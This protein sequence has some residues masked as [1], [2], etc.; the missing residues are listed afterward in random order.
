MKQNILIVDDELAI[1][2]S[3]RGLLEDE[4][5]TVD[6]AD[7]GEKA[8]ACIQAD[9]GKRVDAVLLDIWLPKMD[10]MEVLKTIKET[11]PGIPVIMLSGHA[12]IET[13]VN[14]TKFGAYHFI[15]KPFSAENL[16]LTLSHALRESRLEQE[17]VQ[18][19]QDVSRNQ[20]DIVGESP[21]FTSMIE[22]IGLAAS[23]DAWVLIH[24][25]NGTGKESVAHMVHENSPR[26]G[27]PF[28]E[29]NCAAI[30]EE[31]IESELFGHEK[32]SFTGATAKK[33]GKFD[34]ANQGTLF[35]DEIGDMSLK[36]Q[37]KILRVLQ[38]QRFERVGG[39]KT[40]AVNVRVIAAS[41]KMLDQEI[42][43]GNFREDLFYRLNVLPL[44]VPPLRERKGDVSMLVPF[45]LDYFASIHGRKPK[46]IDPKALEILEQYEWPGN[47]REL[48][49]IVERM[50]IMV[51]G[52]DIK[53]KDIPPAITQAVNRAPTAAPAS[54]HGAANFG[55]SYKEA[56]DAFERAYLRE[57]LESNSW[58]ISRTAEKIKLERSNLHKKIKQLNI[59]MG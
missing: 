35:L 15:E 18:L 5:Y 4:G 23:S 9:S 57:Q 50:M 54:G 52:D 7:T 3:V 59:E 48:K 51:P 47:V 55:G 27:G 58:N 41:N 28:V 30:P 22:Q 38:E 17:N 44:E 2:S 8:L 10:G 49:N 42:A 24:G 14:A 21:E 31:L 53:V 19:K 33:I 40:I 36:T 13:A 34:Q 45:F 16:V 43:A 39:N 11:R 20:H 12:S 26:K 1:R 6:E 56:K 37:A 29:V 25:E 46:K 32:G